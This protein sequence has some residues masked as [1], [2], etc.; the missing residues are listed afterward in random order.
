M[1]GFT[2]AHSIHLCCHGFCLPVAGA[3]PLSE[4]SHKSHLTL[5]LKQWEAGVADVP[6][7]EGTLRDRS[8]ELPPHPGRSALTHIL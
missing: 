6:V 7:Y 4:L 2:L 3:R 8:N 1:I 5:I